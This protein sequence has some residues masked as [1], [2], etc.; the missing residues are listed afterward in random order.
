MHLFYIKIGIFDRQDNDG[1][2]HVFFIC[3]ILIIQAVCKGK[4]ESEV[5]KVGALWAKILGWCPNAES[6]MYLQTGSSYL[7]LLTSNLDLPQ[8]VNSPHSPMGRP[9]CVFSIWNGEGFAIRTKRKG[10]DAQDPQ[11]SISF[12]WGK[13]GVLFFLPM[14]RTSSVLR[15]TEA[16][17]LSPRR[18]L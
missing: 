14:E 7:T 2:L 9:C 10:H 13:E 16:D 11:A 15:A 18:G 3:S 4:S 1:R 17:H 5:Q 12:N 6:R 8:L